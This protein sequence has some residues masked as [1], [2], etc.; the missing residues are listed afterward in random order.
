MFSFVLIHHYVDE[1]ANIN[2]N[3]NAN[4]IIRVNNEKGEKERESLVL[5]LVLG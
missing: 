2:S 1:M 4:N 5:Q 3:K